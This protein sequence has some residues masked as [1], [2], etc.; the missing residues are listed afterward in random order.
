MHSKFSFEPVMFDHNDSVLVIASLL[1]N[2]GR[3]VAEHQRPE[4][5]VGDACRLH[6]HSQTCHPEFKVRMIAWDFSS[7]ALV[8]L[9][10][11]STWASTAWCVFFIP[12]IVFSCVFIILGFFILCIRYFGILSRTDICH[13]VFLWHP[14]HLV[15]C[16]FII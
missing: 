15:L 4:L 7:C 1:C 2:V 5:F 9:C 3:S 6:C 8:I 11:V 14:V 16:T 13:L 10:C 12:Y